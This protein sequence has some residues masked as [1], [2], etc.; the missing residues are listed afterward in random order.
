MWQA[1]VVGKDIENDPKCLLLIYL[2]HTFDEKH[3]TAS[4]RMLLLVGLVRPI[5]ILG[6]ARNR[7]RLRLSRR[8][9]EPALRHRIIIGDLD[10]ALDVY[11]RIAASVWI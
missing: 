8:G 2:S 7:G 5:L 4:H 11:D 3:R 1:A 6:G 9:W 10:V